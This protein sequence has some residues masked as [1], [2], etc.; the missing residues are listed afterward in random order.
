M[1]SGDEGMTTSSAVSLEVV[2]DLADVENSAA[3][4]AEEVAVIISGS[5]SLPELLSPV[6]R[7]AGLFSLMLKSIFP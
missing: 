2:A 4:A 6:L 3:A 7:K 5:E 1:A